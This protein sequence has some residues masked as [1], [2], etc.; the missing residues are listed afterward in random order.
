MYSQHNTFFPEQS[1]FICAEDVF[2]NILTKAEV[3]NEK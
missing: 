2:I 3:E 1:Y